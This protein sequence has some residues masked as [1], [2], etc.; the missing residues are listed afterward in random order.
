MRSFALAGAL[1]LTA[2]GSTI[3][4]AP[5]CDRACLRGFIT[6][7]LDA[8][9]THNPKALPLSPRVRFTEDG[10]EM[11]PGEGLWKDASKIRGYRQDILDVRQGVAAS[12]VVV[13]EGGSPA[14]F[15]L[16]LKIAGKKITEVETQ[17]T[18]K[19]SEG[20][21][22][23]I[24]ALRTAGPAMS[25]PVE[26]SLLMSR[27][28]DI[29]TA[30]FYPAGL[31][32][33]SFVKVDA[34]FAPDAYRIENGARTAGAGCARAGCENIKTQNIMEHP[35]ITT[36]M[37]AVDEELGIVLLRMNFGQTKSYGEGNA[38][39]VWE[40]FK[41]YGGQIHGVEAFMKIMPVSTGSGG[42]E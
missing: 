3:Q 42:W 27:A 30:M 25:A 36:R 37:V 18:R 17:V 26:K 40:A 20:A 16:R 32:I 39:I 7:Y 2:L 23:A 24:D 12:Q 19:K 1:T 38:L 21:L 35:G 15:V 14:L 22:F 10:V 4:A 28:D 8:M 9:L 41:V 5:N 29:K 11:K 34:P 6:Q 33:G 13:E 31:K